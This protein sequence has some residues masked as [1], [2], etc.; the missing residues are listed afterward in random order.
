MPLN[1]AVFSASEPPTAKQMNTALYTYTPG[2][3]F[4]PTGILFHANRS[5]LVEGLQVSLSQASSSVGSL[6]I[7]SGSGNWKNYFD[8]T[9]LFGAGADELYD[10][11]N[12][13]LNPGVSGSAGVAGSIGGNFVIWGFPCFAATTNVRGAGS[14]L[15]ENTVLVSGGKQLSST[16]HDNCSYVLDVVTAASEQKTTLE[17]W[18]ADT[19]GNTFSYR[20]NAVDYSGE[21]TRFYGFWCGVLSGGSVVSSVPAPPTWSN[22]STVASAVLNGAAIGEPLALLNNPPILR[23]GSSVSGA[24]MTANTLEVVSLGA[25]TQVDTY[26]AWAAGSDAYIVPISGVYLVHG[27]VFY[28]TTTVS[29]VQAAIIINTSTVVYGPAYQ[30]ITGINFGCE[31]TRLLDLEAGDE[32]Q[33]GT[34]TN[35]NNTLGSD[36][37]RLVIVWMGAIASASNSLSFTPPSTGYRW[38]A[39]TSGIALVTAFQEHLTNDVSFLIQRPYLLAYQGTAQT[40]LS[41]SAFHTITM[42]TVAG[43]VHGSAGDPYGGWHTSSG[44]FYAAPVDGWYLVTA[45]FT[46]S[47]LA[48]GT[49]SCLAAILQSPAGSQSPDWYQHVSTTSTVLNPG[50]EAIGIYYLRAGDSV[51][52]QYQQQSGSSFSTTVTAGRQSSFGVIWLSE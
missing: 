49:V 40:G 17:G 16:T 14:Y 30:A 44:G 31:V 19:S 52:P 45:G 41:A 3:N 39:G 35:A 20:V 24:S 28:S 21:G 4:T 50:A 26:G 10:T 1:P 43:Q 38:Q 8:N 42:D 2:S 6:T 23:L 5:A 48:S 18:C 12:G 51:Q 37:C 36:L 9:A 34:F 22:S 27:Y 7:L 46:Q 47:A 25:L 32:V 29:N 11:A 15:N 13:W 33:L